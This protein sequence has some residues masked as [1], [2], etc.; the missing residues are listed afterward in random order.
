M[1]RRDTLW[2]NAEDLVF[3]DKAGGWAPIPRVVPLVAGLINN[4]DRV[5]AGHLY[6]VLWARN[7]GTGLVEVH[8]P[9]LLAFESGYAKTAGRAERTF[10]ERIEVLCELRFIETKPRGTRAHAYVLLHDPHRAVLRLHEE[11]PDS[12][13]KGWFE[14]FALRCDEIGVDLAQFRGVVA[15]GDDEMQDEPPATRRRRTSRTRKKPR[16]RSPEAD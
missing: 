4:L 13:P 15:A 2:P 11:R 6:T 16:R 7:F 8:D 9:V 10:R 14:H 1:K 5:N 12:F 3:D